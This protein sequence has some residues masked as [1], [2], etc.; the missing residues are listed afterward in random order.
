MKKSYSLLTEHFF[1]R[2]I[3]ISKLRFLM[4]IVCIGIMFFS[5]MIIIKDGKDIPNGPF[6]QWSAINSHLLCFT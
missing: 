2:Q 6:L 4:K 1:T 3:N 5:V